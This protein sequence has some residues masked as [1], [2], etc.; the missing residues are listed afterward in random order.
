MKYV[1][2]ILLMLPAYN[3]NAQSQKLK[4]KIW[5]WRN[6]TETSIQYNGNQ[7]TDELCKFY[8]EGIYKGKVYADF[9]NQT[10]D[11]FCARLA[12]KNGCLKCTFWLGWFKMNP[13]SFYNIKPDWAGALPYL[14]KT[15]DAGNVKAMM[16]LASEIYENSPLANLDHAKEWYEKA[17]ALGDSIATAR[18]VKINVAQD[19][20]F[21]K[22]MTAYNNKN[23]TDAAKYWAIAVEIN[24]NAQAAYNLAV[25]NANG[26]GFVKNSETAHYF[27]Y[28]ANQYGIKKASLEDGELYYAEGNFFNAWE[29]L[30]KAQQQGCA[31]NQSHIDVAL[32]GRKKIT[33]KWD[34]EA[35]AEEAYQAGVERHAKE[36]AEAAQNNHAPNNV[37]TNNTPKRSEKKCPYCNGAGVIDTPGSKSIDQDKNGRWYN[38]YTPR[39]FKNC[40]YCKGTG[41]L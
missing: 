38:T 13:P 37:S 18:L 40:S 2:A 30:T 22:G 15:A 16:I 21:D 29:Y 27:Y 33:D 19:D 11:E 14:K 31:V 23:Y 36:R 5:A 34:A 39:S 41:Y 1:I 28:K 17:A 6:E 7:Q 24:K 8:H 32:I 9:V 3:S 10:P 35:A 26:T 4:Q 20:P 12:D 25:M